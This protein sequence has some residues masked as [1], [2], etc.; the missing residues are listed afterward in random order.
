MRPFI[1]DSR[2]LYKEL[3]QDPCQA[4]V[5]MVDNIATTAESQTFQEFILHWRS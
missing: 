3:L 5:A 4:L 1:P 2:M